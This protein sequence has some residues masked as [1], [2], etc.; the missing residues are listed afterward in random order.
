VD[1]QRPQVERS[2]QRSPAAAWVIVAAVAGIA[3]AGA[4]GLPCRGLCPVPP[5]TPT[6]SVPV[7]GPAVGRPAPALAV[8][9]LAGDRL[10]LAQYVGHPRVIAFFA[11]SCTDCRSDMATL[12]RVY[13]RYRRHGLVVLGI[14][15]DGTAS[16]ARWMARQVGATFPI[17]YDETGAVALRYRVFSVP[18]TVLVRRDGTVTAI[19]EGLVAEKGLARDLARILPVAER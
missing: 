1:T 18:A 4:V 16:D 19:V 15:I 7:E 3:A 8:P 2:A 14:G 6:A 17:G 9:S 13:R 5:R 12:E 10:T 11:T